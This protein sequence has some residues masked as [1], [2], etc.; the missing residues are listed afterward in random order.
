MSPP[1]IGDQRLL[2]ALL[3]AGDAFSYRASW[4]L[5]GFTLPPFP[6]KVGRAAE[7]AGGPGPVALVRGLAGQDRRAWSQAAVRPGRVDLHRVPVVV[8]VTNDPR[9]EV[10]VAPSALTEAGRCRGR[11]AGRDQLRAAFFHS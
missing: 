1:R 2:L 5:L 6:L 3:V 7:P 10:G 8:I 9:V 4:W 11:A